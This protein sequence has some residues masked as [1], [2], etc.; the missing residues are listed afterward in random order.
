[1]SVPLN[2]NGIIYNYPEVDD[3]DWG[4]DA[5]DWAAA[6]TVGTLQKAGGLFQ[7]L[8]ELDFGTAAGIK[9]LYYKSR[10]TNPAAAGQVRL[11]RA[12]VI[13]F[14]NQANSADLSLGVSASDVLQFNGVDIQSLITVQDTATV[15]LSLVSNVLTANLLDMADSTIK[16]RAVGAGLGA[17]QDLTATQATNILNAFVGDSGSGGLKGL[18]PAPAA[19]DTAAT[20]FLFADGTWQTPPGAG[21]VV[22]PASAT[23]NGFARYDGTTG[24]LLKNY[25][26]TLVNADIDAAAA[27]AYSKLNLASSIVNADVAAAAAIALTKLAATT[28]SRALV[29]NASGFITAATTTATE[30]GYL[31]GVTSAIQTQLNAKLPTT[32]TTTGDIIYSSSGTTSARLPIGATTQFLGASS[33]VPAWT[34]PLAGQSSYSS[35]TT[36]A[37]TDMVATFNSSGGALTITMPTGATGKQ[38]YL[39]KTD[40]SLNA[41]TFTGVTTLNTQNESVL[42]YY[43]GA[44][45]QVIN[46]TIPSIR[47]AYTPTVTGVGTVTNATNNSFWFRIGGNITVQGFFTTGTVSGATVT[48]TLPGVTMNTALMNSGTSMYGRANQVATNTDFVVLADTGMTGAVGFANLANGANFAFGTGSGSFTSSANFTFFFTVPISGWNG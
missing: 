20:K 28:V 23:D 48:V 3:T 19:G 42:V 34:Y 14:R 9:S 41:V 22:G 35:S 25:A 4:P 18:V 27:I 5:T 38:I 13:N 12:D 21:D 37:A 7:I 44:A 29:S 16:G 17:P 45:W 47:V 32:I 1:M 30:I 11:A 39:K 46:R 33:G 43:D 31:N 10:T 2:V 36:I 15:D 8:T 26:A 6:I 24:K 40:S